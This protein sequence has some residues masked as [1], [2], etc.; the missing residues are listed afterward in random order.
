MAGRWSAYRDRI[1]GTAIAAFL[2]AAMGA[3]GIAATPVQAAP[4]AL[5]VVDA[6]TGTVLIDQAG[7]EPRSPAS[8]TKMMTLYMTFEALERGS[9]TLKTRVLMSERAADAP[10]SKLNLDA[11]ETITVEDA[12]KALVTKSANDVA[13]ALAEHFSGSE[14]AFARAMTARARELDMNGTTFKNASG[15][16]DPGQMTTARDMVTLALRLYDSYPRHFQVFT[17]RA[18][19]YGG[20]TYKNHN[21]LMVQMPGINGIKTGYTNASGFNL[22]TSY[23]KDGRHLMAAIFGG[24]SAASRNAAMRI[25]LMR[26]IPRGSTAK[27]RRPLIVASARPSITPPAPQPAPRRAGSVARAQIA[28]AGPV[29]VPA[30][31]AVRP[32]AATARPAS[33]VAPVEVAAVQ[34]APVLGPNVQMAKVRTVDAAMDSMPLSQSQLQSQSAPTPLPSDVTA[35]VRRPPLAPPMSVAAPVP[36]VPMPRAPMPGSPIPGVLGAPARPPSSLNQQHLSLA[37]AAAA[38]PYSGDNTAPLAQ[39]Y[40]LNGPS[41][42]NAAVTPT[43]AGGYDIQIGALA[44]AEDADRLLAQAQA[45]SGAVLAGRAPVRKPAMVNGRTFQRARFTGFDQISAAN[46]CAELARRQFSCLVMK[47]D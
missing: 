32:P 16:P 19:A 15:L 14:D 47:A 42:P 20:K 39:S 21:T 17:T 44:T 8:L 30:P 31:V 33:Q 38:S 26:S 9:I 24:E 29:M 1:G 7:S 3:V 35:A 6:N 10:P 36:A 28:A 27:T 5:L 12:I 40:R 22:V 11:G 2:A 18:F 25:A 4:H 45:K 41:M 46:A 23:E 37:S 43:G 13:I 34:V